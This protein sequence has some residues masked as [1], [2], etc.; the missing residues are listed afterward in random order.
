TAPNLAGSNGQSLDVVATRPRNYVQG[1][2]FTA[3]TGAA[4]QTLGSI[5]EGLSLSLLPLLSKDGKDVDAI[6]RCTVD[7]VEKLQPVLMESTALGGRQRTQIEVPQ[8]AEYRLHERFRWPSNQ[9][10]L[11]SAGMIASPTPAVARPIPLPL[12]SAPR[13]ELLIAVDARAQA[14]PTTGTGAATRPAAGAYHGRY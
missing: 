11:V 14:A 10:L 4:A 13:V 12:S 8:V 6:L 7:Q 3:G 5:N 9:V 1:I 2:S